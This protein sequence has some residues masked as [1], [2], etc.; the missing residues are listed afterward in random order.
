MARGRAWGNAL[1]GWRL[2]GRGPRGRFLPK[3]AGSRKSN[4]RP[5]RNQMAAEQQRISAQKAAR[6]K[7]AK[8][9]AKTAAI[10]GGTALAAG[11]AY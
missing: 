3:G 8:K 9:V 4:Y 7:K 11:G 1:G 2:Q 6:R 5:S 10:V